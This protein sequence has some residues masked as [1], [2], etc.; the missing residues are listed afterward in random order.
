MFLSS[1]PFALLT[2]FVRAPASDFAEIC[3]FSCAVFKVRRTESG[4]N[5]CRAF[6]PVGSALERPPAGVCS[7][8]QLGLRFPRDFSLRTLKTI[9]TR[10]SESHA[11]FRHRVQS[12]A[13]ASLSLCPGY[14]I[15][16]TAYLSIRSPF[17]LDLFDFSHCQALD[18]RIRTTCS[19][20]HLSLERR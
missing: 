8:S 9:Q 4:F 20:I 11:V 14:L 17:S 7:D 6:R 2:G 16:L 3:F 15:G 18:L 13:L 10:D 1:S 12:D 5:C 19:V